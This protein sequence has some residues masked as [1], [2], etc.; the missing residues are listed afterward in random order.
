M[1]TLA[2][3]NPKKKD[4]GMYRYYM[5]K[6]ENIFYHP[7]TIKNFFQKRNNLR[8]PIY[9]LYTLYDTKNFKNY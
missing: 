7:R 4:G 2:I 9:Q 5:N 6:Y 1:K 3:L 8:E